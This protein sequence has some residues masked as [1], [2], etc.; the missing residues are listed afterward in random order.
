MEA[1]EAPPD[2]NMKRKI[3]ALHIKG[4]CL[5]EIAKRLN[6]TP[7]HAKRIVS[8]YQEARLRKK[9]KTEEDPFY[10][11]TPEHEK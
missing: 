5:S 2:K 3:L 4:I 8:L 10:C 1:A 6:I 7:Y 9:K 11:S